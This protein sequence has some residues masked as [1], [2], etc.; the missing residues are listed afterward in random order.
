MNSQVKSA[1]YF[2]IAILVCL[3][4]YFLMFRLPAMI[5]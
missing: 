5:R 4:F 3:I 1:I 2:I